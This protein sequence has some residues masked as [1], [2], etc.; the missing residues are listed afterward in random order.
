M[1]IISV[2][3]TLIVYVGLVLVLTS[4]VSHPTIQPHIK[5][6]VS[7]HNFDAA[8]DVLN[9]HSRNYGKH[10]EFLFHLD[11]GA[12][13]HYAG[14]YRES[15]DAFEKA[16]QIYDD[17]YTK[18][19]TRQAGTWVTN[20]AFAPYGGE[21]F[22]RVMINVFQ[23]LNFALLNDYESALVE[24]RNVD[25]Q[26]KFLNQHYNPEKRNVYKEDAFARFLM[27]IMYESM[28]TMEGVNDAVISYRKALDIY[29][30][31]FLLNYDLNVPSVLSDN[32]LASA[33]ML[34]SG[35]LDE[36]AEIYIIYYRGYV[37]EKQQVKIPI[38]IP[39]GFI[40]QIAFPTYELVDLPEERQVWEVRQEADIYPVLLEKVHDLGRVA[41][42]NLENRRARVIAKTI[43]RSGAR[44]MI[45]KEIEKDMR[46]EGHD[47]VAKW[48]RYFSNLLN[49]NLEQADLRSWQTLPQEIYLGRLV[50]NP[51]TYGVFVGEYL[52]KEVSLNSG[53]K[54]F[55][56]YRD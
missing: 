11:Q 15:I 17:L 14:S 36:K 41:Q 27:G 51:G 38:P 13:L 52:V 34:D 23:A 44:Y 47:K 31:D 21:D 53:E 43:V 20:D 28:G 40:L 6:L 10:S 7:D 33:R 4:C 2:H 55:V 32:A 35:A 12:V 50:L 39:D 24:A 54:T 42:L 37:P 45:E 25:Y 30:E 29:Q 9:T 16:K 19:L 5:S 18:S 8:V 56:S 49:L 22:E 48:F 3:F 26:L 46:K 1:K